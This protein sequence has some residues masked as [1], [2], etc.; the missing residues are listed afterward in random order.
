MEGKGV[1]FSP[2]QK[3]PV[4]RIDIEKN[5]SEKIEEMM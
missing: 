1:T 4:S 2:Q 5:R 3:N